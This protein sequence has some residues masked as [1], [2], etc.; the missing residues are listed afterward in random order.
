MSKKAEIL[1]KLST[2]D[3]VYLSE[4]FKEKDTKIAELQD[5]LAE[6]DSELDKWSTVYARAYVNRQNALIAEKVE[7]KEQLAE[8]EKEI[9]N[10]RSTHIY[11]FYL[12]KDKVQDVYITDLMLKVFNQD[13]ISFCIEKLEKV[14]ENIKKVPITDF[15][16][17]GNFEKMYKQDAIRQIDNQIKQLKGKVDD[18]KD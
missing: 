16:L 8:K 12:D 3:R 13:K 1:H 4:K 10:I 15:D 18:V 7:L 14:K 11:R 2:D 17:S 6:K 5:K 9:E